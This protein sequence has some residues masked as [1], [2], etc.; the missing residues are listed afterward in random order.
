[1]VECARFVPVFPANVSS[2]GSAAAVE[3]D[4]EDDEANDGDDFDDGE[5]EFGCSETLA[6]IRVSMSKFELTF[7][8]SLHA[9]HVDGDNQDE[10][11]GDESVV[12]DAPV[13][14]ELNGQRRCY[15]FE[16]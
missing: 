9:K 7:T 5:D 16:G 14:P 11:N 12:V 1:M 3:D 15:D 8:I 4:S 10:E 2:F 6:M 13:V